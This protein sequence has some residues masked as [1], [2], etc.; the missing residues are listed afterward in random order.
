MNT[1]TAP[2]VYEIVRLVRPLF[3]HLLKAVE[4]RLVGTG[5]TVPMRGVLERLHD[6]G[7][8]TVPQIA[9][10]LMIQRQFV[11]VTVNELVARGWAELAPNPAHRRSPLVRL[12]TA[13]RNTIGGVLAREAEVIAIVAA[14]LD[15]ADVE[16]CRA[17]LARL[18]DYFATVA[19]QD[20]AESDPEDSP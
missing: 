16:V 10:A 4:D 11:Q 14:E 3:R 13:G 9:R 7:Q 19:G 17:V 12:T 6:S 20:G 1:A 15:N 18:T 8:Q 2:S 5:V